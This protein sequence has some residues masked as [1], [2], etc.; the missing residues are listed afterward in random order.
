V[1]IRIGTA[2]DQL[3]EMIYAALPPFDVIFIDADKA[4]YVEY[5]DLSLSLSRPGTLILAD[6]VIRNGIVM[7]ENPADI[8]DRGARAYNGALARH[9]R[10]ESVILPIVRKAHRRHGHLHRPIRRTYVHPQC[11]LGQRV[12]FDVRE[13]F[14]SGG[15]LLLR[16]G[17]FLCA[18][19]LCPASSE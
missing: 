8:H 14:E 1:D 18:R 5:L 2:A 6:N 4:G 10:P 9:P 13:M 12:L 3:R 7:D 15:I 19:L 16:A 11:S 17:A